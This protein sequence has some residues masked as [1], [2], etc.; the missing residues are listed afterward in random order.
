MKTKQQNVEVSSDLY[1]WF[2]E[3]PGLTGRQAMTRI[4]TQAH[5]LLPCNPMTAM[6]PDPAQAHEFMLIAWK[7]IWRHSLAGMK[8]IFSTGELSLIIDIHNGH[9][10]TPQ[11]YG[12][13][14]VAV[15]ISDSIA[16]DGMAEKWDVDPSEILEKVH[17]LTPVQAFCLEL[18]SNGFWYGT[19][20]DEGRD[21]DKYVEQIS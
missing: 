6:F 3:M 16:L 20:P 7:A 8:G 13:N 21:F 11:T 12:S 2:D 4:V 10:V 17:A 9:M 5:E 18:W 14:S 19:Q 1:A 15:G